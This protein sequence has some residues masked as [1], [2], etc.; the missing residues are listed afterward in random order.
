VTLFLQNKSELR[1]QNIGH[2]TYDTREYLCLLASASAYSCARK[3]CAQHYISSVGAQTDVLIETQIGTNTHWG[4]RHNSRN[5]GDRECAFMCAQHYI[6]SVGAHTAGLNETPNWYKLSL[7]QSA[8]VMVVGVCIA[9]ASRAARNYGGA[10]VP[11]KR[12]V[13]ERARSARV[14]EWNMAVQ[15]PRARCAST[16]RE[17]RA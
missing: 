2:G 17:Q 14:H 13:G 6:F 16:R 7:R 10:V 3:T 5:F 4:N 9:H 15:P 11:R 1:L 12:K 8:Q